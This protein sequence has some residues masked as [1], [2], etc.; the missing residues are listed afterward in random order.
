[1][2]EAGQDAPPASVIPTPPAFVIPAPPTFVIPA[3]AGIQVSGERRVPVDAGVTDTPVGIAPA[4]GRRSAVPTGRRGAACARVGSLGRCG[5][6]AGGG[7]RTRGR[8]AWREV[9]PQWR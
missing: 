6:G 2:P 8:Y 9:P 5:R 4:A 1:M 7:S 3:K